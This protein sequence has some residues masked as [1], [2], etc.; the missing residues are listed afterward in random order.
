MDII[1]F[2]TAAKLQ[3]QDFYVASSPPAENFMVVS[4]NMFLPR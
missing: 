3:I 2:F 1:F 4:I